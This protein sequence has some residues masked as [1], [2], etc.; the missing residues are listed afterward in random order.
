VKHFFLGL[1]RGAPV[2]SWR[3]TYGVPPEACPN[4]RRHLLAQLAELL[5]SAHVTFFLRHGLPKLVA[6]LSFHPV[7]IQCFTE[8]L[9]L[10][11][12][13]LRQ[14]LDPIMVLGFFAH[15]LIATFAENL[16]TLNARNLK[17][18]TVRGSLG[19]DAQLR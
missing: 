15:D 5:F 13:G 7:V 19:S 10:P 8:A 17:V 18:P 1:V 6:D 2:H 16:L 9:R 4:L 12:L 11:N 3:G 14:S